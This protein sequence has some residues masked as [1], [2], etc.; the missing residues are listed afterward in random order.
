MRR[1][2]RN[3][4]LLG[5]HMW[6]AVSGTMECLVSSSPL[7]MMTEMK[8]WKLLRM[9]LSQLNQLSP[10]SFMPVSASYTWNTKS[11]TI[12]IWIWTT[13]CKVSL[14]FLWPRCKI[15]DCAMCNAQSN[16]PTSSKFFHISLSILHMRHKIRN[17]AM[18]TDLSDQ[19]IWSNPV[20]V[21]LSIL[22][23]TQNEELY[24]AQSNQQTSSKFLH[25]SLSIRHMRCKIRTVQC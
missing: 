12:W 23:I 22:H 3:N 4:A 20:H 17:C 18:C 25:I 21:S 2:I 6:D 10:H 15:R 16:E 24:N 1:N 14:S 5:Q 7:I 11:G 9:M 13:Q 19:P 8:I